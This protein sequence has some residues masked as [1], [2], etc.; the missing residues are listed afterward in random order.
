MLWASPLAVLVAV[1]A[2]L[3][4]FGSQHVPGGSHAPALLG[5][6]G[7]TLAL[8]LVGAFAA[9]LFARPRPPI[10]TD[11]SRRYAPLLLA[12][13]G[14]A[15]YGLMELSEGHL[16][17]SAFLTAVLASLPLA[18]FVASAA[19]VARRAARQAGARCAALLE[20]TPQNLGSRPAL[21]RGRQQTSLSAAFF[22]GARQGR[23]PPALI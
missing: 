22:P 19:H 6:L 4:A 23:A 14:A 11:R 8:G 17:L 21:L 10:A 20:R 3:V 13:A 16:A 1:L 2:H 5:I 12:A 15:A 7:A 9:G 18:Y